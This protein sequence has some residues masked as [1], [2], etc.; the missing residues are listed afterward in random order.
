M[1]LLNVEQPVISGCDVYPFL[2]LAPFA[3]RKYFA[4]FLNH[5][6]LTNHAVEVG[7]DQASF[8]VEFLSEWRGNKLSCVDPYIAP[9]R[10]DTTREEDL[11]MAQERLSLFEGR[12]EIIRRPSTLACRD[13]Q[14]QSLD[15]VY[16]DGDHTYASVV[17][18]LN[19][20]FPKIRDGG[21]LAGH[22]IVMPGEFPPAWDQQ[23]QPAVFQFAAEHALSVYLVIE[24]HGLPW[25]FFVRK[26]LKLS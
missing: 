13:F 11:L 17:E 19:C 4:H 22:D 5:C 23:I 7:T 25:S 3:D 1:E 24:S 2:Q 8:A 20:W 15:F 16:V 18:D 21:I 14:N 9:M 6:G 12:W 10:K 26:G